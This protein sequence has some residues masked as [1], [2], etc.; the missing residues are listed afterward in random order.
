MIIDGQIMTV[1]YLCFVDLRP[2]HN[3]CFSSA[4]GS[5]SDGT[6]HENA[7]Y[8]TLLNFASVFY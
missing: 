7:A 1:A 6:S 4:V 5:V 8:D 3:T 2:N